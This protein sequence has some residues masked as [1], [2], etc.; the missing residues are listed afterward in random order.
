MAE[1]LCITSW[2]H[3]AFGVFR[4]TIDGLSEAKRRTE[5]MEWHEIYA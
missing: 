5:W 4:F 3:S 2:K 1:G